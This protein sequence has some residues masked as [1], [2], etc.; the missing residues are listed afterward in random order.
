MKTSI[1]LER[2]GNCIRNSRD[3]DTFSK[4]RVGITWIHIPVGVTV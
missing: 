2:E 4:R 1:L 3:G